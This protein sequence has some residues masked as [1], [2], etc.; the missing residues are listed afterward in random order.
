MSDDENI[1]GPEHVISFDEIV[2]R[3]K[4]K[5]QIDASRDPHS[6]MQEAYMRESIAE[7]RKQTDALLRME[8]MWKEF[9]DVNMKLHEEDER[10]KEMVFRAMAKAHPGKSREEIV[11]MLSDQ[12]S[13]AMESLTEMMR[14]IDVERQGNKF[15]PVRV[16]RR[17]YPRIEDDDNATTN[18]HDETEDKK[19]KE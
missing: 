9:V 7:Q 3:L 19:E 11:S 2:S 13:K 1:W 14:K 17:F 5:D 10:N 6:A 15:E 8:K 18:K 4:A 12:S 16:E